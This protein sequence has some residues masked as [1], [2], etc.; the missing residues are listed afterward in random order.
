MI[1]NYVMEL[2]EHH[3]DDTPETFHLRDPKNHPFLSKVKFE[4]ARGLG[5]NDIAREVSST[6]LHWIQKPKVQTSIKRIKDIYDP[7]GMIDY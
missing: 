1:P 3:P 4:F 2:F 6:Y 5:S 7:T